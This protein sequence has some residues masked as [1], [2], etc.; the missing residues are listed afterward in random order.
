MNSETIAKVMAMSALET[1]NWLDQRALEG[2]VRLP[3]EI[4]SR[5]MAWAWPNH[6]GLAALPWF[7]YKAQDCST[8]AALIRINLSEIVAK[9]LNP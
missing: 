9:A 1:A 8:V 7:N 5:L 6:A 3:A 4:R 2:G